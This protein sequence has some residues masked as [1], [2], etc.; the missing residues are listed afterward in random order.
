LSFFQGED[1][2]EGPRGLRGR[3][4]LPGPP[5]MDGLPCSRDVLTDFENMCQNCCKKP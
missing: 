3:P 5:G 2:R 1:G 4:G